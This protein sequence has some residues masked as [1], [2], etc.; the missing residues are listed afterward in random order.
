[1]FLIRFIYQILSKKD[2]EKEIKRNNEILGDKIINIFAVSNKKKN[3]PRFDLKQTSNS[4]SRKWFVQKV[5]HDNQFM[6][7]RLVDKPSCYDKNEW[8]RDFEKS[9]NYKKNICVFP[10]IKFLKETEYD[11]IA[12]TSSPK[13]LEANNPYDPKQLQIRNKTSH[14]KLKN[15]FNPFEKLYGSRYFQNTEDSS[16][17]LF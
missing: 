14:Q 10:S 5:E 17:S 15:M 1:L 8:K 12:A 4:N 13:N 9:Q 3:K 2:K 16:S 7:K 6:L 11:K